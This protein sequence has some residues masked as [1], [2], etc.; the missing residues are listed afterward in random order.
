MTYSG[1]Q[2]TYSVPKDAEFAAGSYLD[3]DSKYFDIHLDNG[4]LTIKQKKD[5]D[6][7]YGPYGDYTLYIR[8]G[9][10][11]TSLIFHVVEH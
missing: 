5:V 9:N 11:Y 7:V 10:V 4:T 2:L 8:S 6:H 1:D 3:S